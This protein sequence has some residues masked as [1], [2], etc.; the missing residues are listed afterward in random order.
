MPI[1]PRKSNPANNKALI[2]KT[3]IASVRSNGS[4]MRAI[5]IEN[6]L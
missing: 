3:K 4:E 5:R 2:I 6:G 1:V